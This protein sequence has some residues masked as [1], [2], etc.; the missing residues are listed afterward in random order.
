MKAFFKIK[1]VDD[2]NRYC[3]NRFEKYYFH[4][5]DKKYGFVLYGHN[6]LNV[7]ND[8]AYWFKTKKEAYK[9]INGS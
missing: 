1:K 4:T 5:F 8:F 6:C 7:K 9:N 3:L 2:Y